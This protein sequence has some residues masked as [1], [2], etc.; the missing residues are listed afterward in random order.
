MSS[1]RKKPIIY[2]NTDRPA[3][4]LAGFLGSNSES[5]SDLYYTFKGMPITKIIFYF[6]AWPFIIMAYVIYGLGCLLYY[7]LKLLIWALSVLSKSIKTKNYN[8]RERKI[9][10]CLKKTYSFNP[11]LSPLFIS[12]ENLFENYLIEFL[13][14][15]IK[16]PIKMIELAY[17]AGKIIIS[18]SKIY[19]RKEDYKMVAELLNG[20]VDLKSNWKELTSF[21]QLHADLVKNIIEMSKTIVK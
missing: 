14:S 7:L 16:K 12:K 17:D 11:V 5:K 6:F 19:K 20:E 13:A 9:R 3:F 4:H 1:K 10:Q 15:K 21:V 2:K 18:I 8:K